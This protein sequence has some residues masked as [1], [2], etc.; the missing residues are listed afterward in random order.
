MLIVREHG[1]DSDKLKMTNFKNYTLKSRYEKN[2]MTM[3]GVAIFWSKSVDLKISLPEFGVTLSEDKIYECC[4]ALI[5]LEIGKFFIAG[6]SP[7][8][9]A[10]LFTEKMSQYI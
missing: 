3:G 4:E 9:S 6:R 2:C 5:H 8:S 7:D 10:E 1:L